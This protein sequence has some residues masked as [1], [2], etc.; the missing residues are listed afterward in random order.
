MK[1][2]P[3]VREASSH[4]ELDTY[5]CVTAQHR[6]MLDSVMRLTGMKVQ[7]DLDVMRPGQTLYETTSLVLTGM[8]EVF[9]RVKPDYLL[10]QG[11]TTTAMAAAL[12]AF[13]KKTKVGHIEAGLRSGNNYSPWPEEMNRKIVGDIADLHFAPTTRAR[14]NLLAEGK[15]ASQIAITGN[16]A[17]DTLLHF[18]S[19][20]EFSG[21]LKAELS[22]QFEFLDSERKL[23]VVTGHRR[24]NFDGGLDRICAALR[25]LTMRGDVQVVYAVHPNPNVQ[26]VV[27]STLRGIPGIHL[28]PP[29]DYLPFVFLLKRAHLVL[30]DSG[31][32]QEE[33]PSLGKPV[34]VL[35]ENT[36]RPEGVDAGTAK[37]V[38]TDVDAIVGAAN[39]LLDD[40]RAYEQMSKRHNPFGDG[41][42]GKRIVQELLNHG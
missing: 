23:I 24:E 18:S 21:T 17:I 37:L 22:R 6:D 2:F 19:E 33:A 7:F 1:C 40:K 41:H 25:V 11:D 36:E 26:R 35:R 14:D 8:E 28:I 13:Y 29:Q 5:V 38:G 32:I 15:P 20:I 42:A 3:V 10:V 34:L 31:G 27:D 16:T 30:T 4:D 12:A 9:D 39:Q